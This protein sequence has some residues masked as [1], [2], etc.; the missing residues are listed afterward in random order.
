[1]ATDATPSTGAAKHS[2]LERRNQ[3]A[4]EWTEE[5]VSKTVKEVIRQA[6]VSPEIRALALKD[7]LAAIKKV[8]GE[9]VPDGLRVSMIEEG[10]GK[11]IHASLEFLNVALSDDD[12][13]KVA[14][15]SCAAISGR[16][17][18]GRGAVLRVR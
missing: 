5:E 11:D 3:M 1:M 4:K 18:C 2:L 6:E 15:G 16:C 8:T 9:D 10:T 17:P 12:L 7:P 14:G 13:D